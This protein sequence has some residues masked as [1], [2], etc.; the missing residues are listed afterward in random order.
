M[1]KILPA[2]MVLCLALILSACVT[3][4]APFSPHRTNTEAHQQAQ[5]NQDC[6][7]CHVIT[8]VGNKHK[9]TDDCLR[10]HRIVQ[11]D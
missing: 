2:G 5:T 1:K 4:M 7:G 10:C 3:R 6:I 8:E 11:G 9:S